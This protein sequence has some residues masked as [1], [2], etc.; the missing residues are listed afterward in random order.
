MT[1]TQRDLVKELLE[2]AL[3][4][5]AG[6]RHR[7][8][9]ACCPD[10][11]V[12]DEVARLV[13]AHENGTGILEA[14]TVDVNRESALVNGKEPVP[15]T[16]VDPPFNIADEAPERIDR[17]R[18]LRRISRG[19][20]GAVYLAVRDDDQIRT[21]VALKV[22]RRGMDT[23]DI[24]HRFKQEQQLL[25]ALNHPNIARVMDAG[26]MPDG[27]PYFV[28][29]YVN[30]E[31][32]DSYC[33][34]QHLSIDERLEL[35]RKVCSAVHFAHQNL[36]IHRDLKPS[37]IL[38][39]EDGEPKLLDFGIA[40]VV[41]PNIAGLSLA[42]EQG[43]RLMTPE[44]ASP[45][46]V[47][48]K[49]LTIAT[50]VYSLGVVLYELLAGHSPYG[51]T[52]AVEHELFRVISDVDP[53]RPSSRVMQKETVEIGN[54]TTRLVTPAEVAKT[55]DTRP[56]HLRRRLSGDLDNIVLKAMRK[57]PR[58]RYQSAEQMAE[59]I[60]RH[61][62][63]MPVLARPDTVWYRSAKFIRRHRSG[64]AAAAVGIAVLAGAAAFSYIQWRRAEESLLL[65]RAAR[66]RAGEWSRMIFDHA[67]QDQGMSVRG[68]AA[69]METVKHR[70]AEL[71]S[72]PS[73]DPEVERDIAM[74]H[75]VLGQLHSVNEPRLGRKTE[76][77]HHLVQAERL[78]NTLVNKDPSRTDVRHE[79][80]LALCELGRVQAGNS[81][82][83]DAER[84]LLKACELTAS[85]RDAETN[86]ES[87]V[88]LHAACQKQL[89]DVLLQMKRRDEAIEMYRRVER[90]RDALVAR[91]PANRTYRRD[92]TTIW[93]ALGK[94]L[95]DA[96]DQNQT[97]EIERYYKLALNER[98]RLLDE[99]SDDPS[100]PE[101]TAK[102]DV[103]NAIQNIAL[104][105]D[106]TKRDAD[107][108]RLW[109]EALPLA[110]EL[111]S[112][113]PLDPR[114]ALDLTSLLGRLGDRALYTPRDAENA[115][116]D[117]DAAQVYYKEG[118]ESA[119]RAFALEPTDP[120]NR[121]QQGLMLYGL[122]Q[123]A[124]QRTGDDHTFADY[125]RR[126]AA[127]LDEVAD[128]YGK[129]KQYIEVRAWLAQRLEEIRA[130]SDP[131][132]K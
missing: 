36:I 70:L 34:T 88:R 122:A 8:I 38:V 81:K 4:K 76:S 89:A 120:E 115:R 39:G 35:F 110:R 92:R 67:R 111:A 25:A 37:N 117:I 50:D 65:T 12:R 74:T 59:D 63:G 106:K 31:P 82:T 87:H 64:V 69:L 22:I 72:E 43:R 23:D 1:S 56:S 119:Q 98:R 113:N 62:E 16:R 17:Y 126:A 6:D 71:E 68:R 66:A 7:F 102:R 54:G 2:K 99:S 128:R 10:T 21:Q 48:G 42:T 116:A 127:A 51:V 55:R 60:E 83:T 121:Y 95:E 112:S 73:S 129:H 33:D 97:I 132:T 44:Y 13:A 85:L 46:Q 52:R 32:I 26:V 30:G 29:E 130:Q 131:V 105:Y 125:V 19:G 40:K 53:E 78:L 49:G 61:L 57:L 41:N 9:A 93:V 77:E 123:I 124:A 20:M 27:R 18:V 86:D 24:V 103:L 109:D 104:V 107:A 79:Y 58:R 118:V 11:A 47:N 94:C 80:A 108:Q 28:M 3:E 84:T 96:A 100:Y 101:R 114:A 91:N 5:P 14:P 90:T 45:E 15:A 75:V